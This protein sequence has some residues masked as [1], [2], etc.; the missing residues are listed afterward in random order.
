[1]HE[2]DGRLG[3]GVAEVAIERA[4]LRR[5][6]HALVHDG[7]GAHGAHVER[8]A[9]KRAL[10]LGHLLDHAARH[11]QPALEVLAGGRRLGPAQ[12]RLH[13]VRT[14][15]V[16]RVAQ[17]M[18]V[19]GHLAPE[20]QGH[21]LLGASV[22]EHAARVAVALGVLREE[23]HGDAVVALGRQDVPLALRLPAEQAVRDLE[24]HAGAVARVLLQA[25]AAAVLQ[26]HEHRERVVQHRVRALAAKARQRADAACVVLVLRSVQ[27]LGLVSL[28]VAARPRHLGGLLGIMA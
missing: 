18:R 22:L 13:D 16:R 8:L 11:V 14:A 9:R 26:V 20:Q 7:V 5:H 1:M 6:E 12:E 28:P 25:L 21:A 23:Q 24:Q 10:L 27:P 3:P 15:A 2:R 19:N 17:V 4:Q